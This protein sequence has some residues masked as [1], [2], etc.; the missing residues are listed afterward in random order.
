MDRSTLK[1][2]V[3]AKGKSDDSSIILSKD[4]HEI[5]IMD[6]LNKYPPQIFDY[7]RVFVESSQEEVFE[8]SCRPIV[9]HVLDGFDG[10]ILAYGPSGTGKSHTIIGTES[11]KGIYYR[12]ILGILKEAEKISTQKDM[13]ITVSIIE[14]FGSHIRDIGLCYKD[15]HSVNL[16]PTHHLEISEINGRVC[17]PQ[18]TE[19]SIKTVEDASNIIQQVHDMRITLEA[20]MGKYIDKAS[21]IISVKI[22]QK[23]KT[24]AWDQ[25]TESVL[26]IVELAGS[27]KPKERKGQDFYDSINAS[28]SFHAIS[29]CLSNLNSISS[30]FSDHKLTRILENSFKNNS[31]IALIG[32]INCDKNFNEE[33]G[34][35][36]NFLDKCKAA[37]SSIVFGESSNTDSTIKL[38]QDERAALKEKLKRIETSQEDQLKKIVEVLGVESDIDSLLQASAGSKELQKLAAQRDAVAKVDILFRKNREMEKRLDE[39]KKL[40]EKIKKIDIQTQEKHL[41]Q[42]LEIKDEL[43][44][45]K[46]LQE[47]AKSLNDHTTKS[48]VE[49]KT[50]ELNEMLMNSQKLLNEKVGILNKLPKTIVSTISLPNIQDVKDFGKS[51]MIKEYNFKLNQ[52]EKDNKAHLQSIKKKFEMHYKQREDTLAEIQKNFESFKL[53]KENEISMLGKETKQLFDIIKFQKNVL[54]G[55]KSGEYNQHITNIEFPEAILPEFPTQKTFPQ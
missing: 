1:I 40:L 45:L 16:I 38:L 35:T 39:N 31:M 20:K 19:Y 33:T 54:N 25:F 48:Q 52:Q 15:P 29:K 30:N 4:L 37:A 13:I 24:S 23:Y 47:E 14:L 2:F 50:F 3:R 11:D 26:F 27:E 51:E 43:N 53:S 8:I 10:L 28:S 41:R 22:K 44:R 9:D 32:T 6:P 36:L 12:T 17:V 34:R 46:D 55:I 49:T 5:T 21:L 18:A 7:Y 42:V